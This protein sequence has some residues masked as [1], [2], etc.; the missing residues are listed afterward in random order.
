MYDEILERLGLKYEELTEDERNILDQW[1]SVLDSG[2]VSVSRVRDYIATMKDLVIEKLVDEPEFNY[3][4]I[5]K[6]PNRTHLLLKA[7][8]KNYTLLEAML[9][10]P[11]KAKEKIEQHIMAIAG[12]KVS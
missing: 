12:K 2:E 6:V 7:R 4:F 3:I 9:S 8:L 10:T 1:V 5:F 11:E